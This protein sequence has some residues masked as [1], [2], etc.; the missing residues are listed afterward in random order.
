MCESEASSMSPNIMNYSTPSTYPLVVII[1]TWRH[2]VRMSVSS[3]LNTLLHL[4]SKIYLFTL[5]KALERSSVQ[6]MFFHYFT[7]DSMSIKIIGG[8]RLR[9]SPSMNLMDV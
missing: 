7:T 2:A 8:E 1:S 5:S 9:L 6:I 3:I 4:F